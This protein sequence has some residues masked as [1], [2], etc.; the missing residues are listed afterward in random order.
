MLR[1]LGFR[2][3]TL[4]RA[5]LEALEENIRISIGDILKMTALA[6]SG[7]PGGSLSSLHILTM[8]YA[9]STVSDETVAPLF[10]DKV[11]VSHGHISPGVYTVLGRNGYFDINECLAH[12]RNGSLFSG[13]IEREVPGVLWGTGNLG[14]GLSTALAFAFMGKG[15]HNVFALMGD[16]EQAKGQLAE[17]RELAFKL[18][19]PNLI[20]IVDYNQK[21]ISGS[22]HDVLPQHIK[23]KYQSAGW[24][25]L[26]CNGHDFNDLY[27]V[28]RAAVIKEG[29]DHDVPTMILARTVMGNGVPFMQGDHEYHGKAPTIKQ[30]REELIRLGLEDDLEHLLERRQDTAPLKTLESAN[31]ILTSLSPGKPR[32]YVEKTAPRTAYGNALLDIARENIPAGK[33]MYS[34]DCDLGASTKISSILKEFPD[35]FIQCGIQEHDAAA[36]AAALSTI[37]HGVFWST[38]GVFGVDEVYNQLRLSDINRTSLNLVCTHLGLDVGEDG[39]THQSIDYIGLLR[40]LF[41]F[42]VMVPADA[43]QVDRA[44][45]Y[46]ASRRGNNF[47]GMGRN[48][49]D[50]LTKEDGTPFFDANYQF[51]YGRDDIIR[52][53]DDGV[54]FAMGTMVHNAMQVREILASRYGIDV[55]VVNKSC[56]T[57]VDLRTINLGVSKGHIFTYED[58][59]IDTGMGSTLAN[60]IADHGLSVRFRKFGVTRYGGSAKAEVLYRNAGLDPESVASEIANSMRKV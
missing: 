27:R 11:A 51:E 60:Y 9:L 41:G 28:L 35:N 40:N 32:V 44:I 37:S 23:E 47:V 3:P 6:G 50:V 54:I 21:Q 49:L 42:R 53:G 14:Q 2:Q 22:I 7:H 5:I 59:H 45:R 46:A 19:L 17:A 20:A 38:F 52:K 4:D 25:V 55:A 56:P 43:N 15:K 58:H 33:M 1:S 16:G 13:H 8:I 39:R 18:R 10:R 48:D 26:E 34:I 57:V 36:F 30:C 24:N 31:H 29:L 12:F